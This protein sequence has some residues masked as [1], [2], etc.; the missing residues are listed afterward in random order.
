MDRR[1]YYEVRISCSD[2][3]TFDRSGAA[4][5][6]VKTYINWGGVWVETGRTE[7]VSNTT[8]PSYTTPSIIP[9][10]SFSEFYPAFLRFAVFE[11]D[12]VSD[13]FV[14]AVSTTLKDLLYSNISKEDSTLHIPPFDDS[15]AGK[16]VLK[17]RREKFGFDGTQ[18]MTYKEESLLKRRGPFEGLQFTGSMVLTVDGVSIAEGGESA[19]MP[20]VKRL[21]DLA[22]ERKERLREENKFFI[23]GGG[24]SFNRWRKVATRNRLQISFNVY[25]HD[26]R[27]VPAVSTR[28]VAYQGDATEEIR[29]QSNEIT[30]VSETVYSHQTMVRVDFPP[31]T[32][33]QLVGTDTSIDRERLLVFEFGCPGYRGRRLETSLGELVKTA[34]NNTVRL[35]G[36]YSREKSRNLSD[37]RYDTQMPPFDLEILLSTG[38]ETVDENRT[39]M[40]YEKYRRDTITDTK[41]RFNDSKR[42]PSLKSA[43]AARKEQ[44]REDEEAFEKAKGKSFTVWCKSEQML[45]VT[46]KL[47]DFRG[48]TD[49]SVHWMKENGE[50]IRDVWQSSMHKHSTDLKQSWKRN[51]SK[52]QFSLRKFEL[53]GTKNADDRLLVFELAHGF[54]LTSFREIQ[55]A[56]ASKQKSL[57]LPLQYSETQWEKFN[58]PTSGSAAYRVA[59]RLDIKATTVGHLEFAERRNARAK[60]YCY[61]D[62]LERSKKIKTDKSAL[63]RAYR[64]EYAHYKKNVIDR[65]RDGK[66]PEC[67][68]QH[69]GETV[70]MEQYRKGRNNL[71]KRARVIDFSEWLKGA[72]GLAISIESINGGLGMAPLRHLQTPPKIFSYLPNNKPVAEVFSEST[73]ESVPESY[74]YHGST[75]VPMKS[76]C[77]LDP[78][79]LIVFVIKIE[80]PF[81]I[82]NSPMPPVEM[83]GVTSVETLMSQHGHAVVALELAESVQHAFGEMA[84]Y[85]P[86][87]AMIIRSNRA[88]VPVL[89]KAARPTTVLLPDGN[90]P[91]KVQQQC[92]FNSFQES[93]LRRF[94]N[95]HTCMG[96]LY[97]EWCKQKVKAT[98]TSNML[99]AKGSGERFLCNEGGVDMEQFAGY[100]P[101]VLRALNMRLEGIDLLKR[102]NKKK[103]DKGKT[104]D[105]YAT[106]SIIDK[107]FT[108]D[109]LANRD[110]ASPLRGITTIWKSAVVQVR[111]NPVWD[112]IALLY[113]EGLCGFEH[114]VNRLLLVQIFD[115]TDIAEESDAHLVGEFV[116]SVK[117]MLDKRE[118]FALLVSPPQKLLSAQKGIY[119]EHSGRAKIRAHEVLLDPRIRSH[120]DMVNE[121]V[122]SED[123][124]IDEA[125]KV[126]KD[127]FELEGKRAWYELQCRK[128]GAELIRPEGPFYADLKLYNVLLKVEDE[129]RW[130]YFGAGQGVPY[131]AWKLGKRALSLQF[132]AMGLDTKSSLFATHGVYAKISW[133]SPSLTDGSRRQVWVSAEKKIL[134]RPRWRRVKIPY[135]LLLEDEST[136]NANKNLDRLLMFEIYKKNTHDEDDLIGGFETSVKDL[137]IKFYARTPQEPSLVFHLSNRHAEQQAIEKGTLYLKSGTVY[138]EEVSECMVDRL[139]PVVGG[140][141]SGRQAKSA[142]ELVSSVKRGGLNKVPEVLH[143]EYMWY[144]EQTIN[145]G[146]LILKNGGVLSQE[147]CSLE[148]FKSNVCKLKPEEEKKFREGGG[149]PFKQWDTKGAISFIPCA[150]N[151]DKKDTFSQSDAYL[152][153]S[154]VKDCDTTGCVLDKQTVWS[155][156]KQYNANNANPVWPEV[157]LPLELF[158]QAREAAILIE[159]FDHNAIMDDQLIGAHM[160]SF[161][162]LLQAINAG[163]T[164]AEQGFPLV[165]RQ[166]R[167]ETA[168][169]SVEPYTNSGMLHLKMAGWKSATA[170][171]VSPP[172]C[173]VKL[174]QHLQT[175][176]ESSRRYKYYQSR[177]LSQPTYPNASCSFEQWSLSNK[178]Q[179]FMETYLY[180]PVEGL[181]VSLKFLEG[182]KIFKYPFQAYVSI[183]TR[184]SKSL[185]HCSDPLDARASHGASF[186]MPFSEYYKNLIQLLPLQKHSNPFKRLFIPLCSEHGGLPTPFGDSSASTNLA[187]VVSFSHMHEQTEVSYSC[188]TSLAELTRTKGKKTLVFYNAAGGHMKLNLESSKYVTKQGRWK[189]YKWSHVPKDA[190]EH[191]NRVYADFYSHAEVYRT[192]LCIMLPRVRTFQHWVESQAAAVEELEKS[193]TDTCV[194][195]VT[196]SKTAYLCLKANGVKGGWMSGKPSPYCVINKVNNVKL[197]CDAMGD[198]FDESSSPGVVCV[199]KTDCVPK[200]SSPEW[201]PISIGTSGLGQLS[202]GDLLRLDIRDYSSSASPNRLIARR[203][204]SLKSMMVEQSFSLRAGTQKG[205]SCDISCSVLCPTAIRD[206]CFKELQLEGLVPEHWDCENLNLFGKTIT[207]MSEEEGS[208]PHCCFTP[209][210]VKRPWREQ[211]YLCLSGSGIDFK[212]VREFCEGVGTVDIFSQGLSGNEKTTVSSAGSKEAMV[213]E[214]K[215][216]LAE[217]FMGLEKTETSLDDNCSDYTST[218]ETG[219]DESWTNSEAAETE[220]DDESESEWL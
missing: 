12:E 89:S 161:V 65:F 13:H 167:L 127:S 46:V 18:H 108:R 174:W 120:W 68:L 58:Q 11:T 150:F 183:P 216:L 22:A 90:C 148:Q 73:F 166:R 138:I 76:L 93:Q 31:C 172:N 104:R 94:K 126:L 29:L 130:K 50:F 125:T 112:N 154:F 135:S 63:D 140:P 102:E 156:R 81:S 38:T 190:I 37:M 43:V 83:F 117:K 32:V 157:I 71:L 98:N 41:Y 160:M 155:N 33:E 128:R 95:N 84:A 196:E 69:E 219:T 97:A 163:G 35:E 56:M 186:Q 64:G 176:P 193:I 3:P 87:F 184:F 178:K 1:D 80:S 189:G 67:L 57:F 220:C 164:D 144:T 40:M 170:S 200:E 215:R 9:H 92:E 181:E 14:G 143:G 213:D 66:R 192:P 23:L 198:A 10:V 36:S 115:V 53:C 217:A 47:I 62:V 110:R 141:N 118:S 25:F 185:A 86:P 121:Q 60:C 39:I 205:N 152:S 44:S 188:S 91:L 59:V 165:N 168:E 180:S 136:H 77:N 20:T 169:I 177:I 204:T 179:T 129:Q 209:H 218:D 199:H 210:S 21:A 88:R 101:R 85:V 146:K 211:L 187:L 74:V 114:Q 207:T 99:F 191:A 111:Q 54:V 34:N 134:H 175:I 206:K 107:E 26:A 42:R 173:S 149:I 49:V 119:Y 72:E 78:K 16:F 194:A 51:S 132:S 197:A 45:H 96:I 137:L 48:H 103:K 106:I 61:E 75:Y 17:L 30:E 159:C 201:D 100:E 158:L 151:L 133:S 70:G 153:L 5:S 19:V 6:Y 116:T 8:C 182:F 55:E 145:R 202:A 113:H 4:N 124:Y 24:L 162:Q 7:L 203:V 79:L 82:A 123:K 27:C 147:W 109:I 15:E 52:H 2:L 122:A 139:D 195:F 214:G 105:F 131:E 208:T 142:L 212:A 28:M 171:T